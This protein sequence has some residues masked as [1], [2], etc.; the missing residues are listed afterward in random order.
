MTQEQDESGSAG[1]ETAGANRTGNMGPEVGFLPPM[2][3][4]VDAPELRYAKL[5]RIVA[6]IVVPQLMALHDKARGGSG[7]GTAALPGAAEIAELAK[8]VLNPQSDEATDFLL[9]L[10]NDGVSLDSLYADLLEPTARHLGALWNDDKIDFVDVT[11]G[12]SRLQRIVLVFEGLDTVEAFD[13][14]RKVLLAVAPGEQHSYGSAIVQKFL[15]AAGWHVWTCTTPRLEEAADVAAQEWFGVIGFSLG[16]DIHHEALAAAIA[17]VRQLSLN[18]KVGIMVGG[19]AIARNPQWV[20]TL[21]AD[22]TA[23]NG[24]ATV[25]LAKKLLAESLG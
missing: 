6:E 10:K 16:S 1:H 4:A 5:S 18:R 22:G 9:R 13:A 2:P 19:S 20:E 23:A 21:G 24:P 12:V 3:V 7:P 17:R 11:L 25:I 8:L 15:R 14:K